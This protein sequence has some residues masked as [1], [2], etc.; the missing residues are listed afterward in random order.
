MSSGPGS[1]SLLVPELEQINLSLYKMRT[2]CL[3]GF[4]KS[5]VKKC[6]LHPF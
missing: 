1:A 2:I 6:V 3:S 4:C 5:Q